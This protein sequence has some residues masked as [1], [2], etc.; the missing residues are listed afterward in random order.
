M[1]VLKFIRPKN[2][3]GIQDRKISSRKYYLVGTVLRKVYLCITYR[4]WAINDG[5]VIF[6]VVELTVPT[7]VEQ[8]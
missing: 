1:S 2:G 3:V 4:S 5:Y 7:F 8:K 6:A